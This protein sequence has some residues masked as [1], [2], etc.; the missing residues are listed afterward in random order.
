MCVSVSCTVFVL[1][2]AGK[3]YPVNARVLKITD[4]LERVLRVNSKSG[5]ENEREYRSNLC[6]TSAT[7]E[8]KVRETFSVQQYQKTPEENGNQF[9]N[10][11]CNV[12]VNTRSEDAS[13]EWKRVAGILD[14]VLLITLFLCAFITASAFS[15]KLYIETSMLWSGIED[16]G[17]V[18]LIPS[19]QKTTHGL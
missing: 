8:D 10:C 2:V 4:Y 13:A 18:E 7:P 1:H 11:N 6:D 12:K 17:A 9:E 15:I 16:P 19:D 5:I 14:R 3:T